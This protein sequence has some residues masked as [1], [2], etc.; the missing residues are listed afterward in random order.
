MA[1]AD[2]VGLVWV[3]GWP[4]TGKSTCGDYLASC[5]FAHID[6]D[7]DFMYPARGKGPV[8]GWRSSW[9][10]FF[11]GKEPSTAEFGPFLKDVCERVLE[12]READ[13]GQKIVITQSLHRPGRDYVRQQ[14]GVVFFIGLTASDEKIAA[15]L[16]Y[17]EQR[18]YSLM[19]QDLAAAFK[20]RTGEELSKAAYLREFRGKASTRNAER[21]GL[22]TSDCE[23]NCNRID[24]TVNEGAVLPRVR[25][26]LGLPELA[27]PI[28]AT[29]AAEA[30]W[31][32][33]AAA[34]PWEEGGE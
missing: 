28:D 11:A 19:G 30:T 32:K 9:M 3:T 33:L 34:K 16:M 5:G 25:A 23:P 31:R 2:P 12:L 17:K 29:D 4:G 10:D 7:A 24:V 21:A 8:G 22:D 13:A 14:L 6:V 15:R 26:L 27:S 18:Y 1:R 20:A